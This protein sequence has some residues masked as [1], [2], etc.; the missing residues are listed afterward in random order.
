MIILLYLFLIAAFI[1]IFVG[2]V[3]KEPDTIS[4]FKEKVKEDKNPLLMPLLKVFTPLNK[5][6]LKILK[7]EHALR[8]KLTLS[9]WKLTPAEFLGMREICAIVFP[10]L[11]YVFGLEKP[12]WL[13]SAAIFGL[14]L[15]GIMMKSAINRRKYAIVRILPETV[16]LLGLC[17]GAGL[18][19]MSA[20]RWVIDKVR[21]NP[22]I[23][24]LSVVLK[25]INIGKSRTEALRDMSKRLEI[26]DVTSFVR[27]L[28]Q[29]D[30]MGTPVE[31]AFKILSED[32]RM[33]RFHRGE[34]Q[35]MKAPL[36]MLIPLIFCILP[37]ILIIVAG[38]ILIKFIKGDLFSGVGM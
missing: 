32:T 27:T 6:I 34:R 12:I 3:P 7:L 29:A 13:I 25:E 8:S 14:I 20:V 5:V 9:R 22:L 28:I 35:A 10:L 1:F 38:P 16:D 15:P 36:K 26:P 18:D 23:E 11:L 33:R 30:R 4:V 17:V 24:E 2:L 21:F 31:E 19:F 37:V